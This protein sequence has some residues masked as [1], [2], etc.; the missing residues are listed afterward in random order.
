MYNGKHITIPD[1][2]VVFQPEIE[3]LQRSTPWLTEFFQRNSL[4]NFSYLDG[5]MSIRKLCSNGLADLIDKQYSSYLDPLGGVGIDAMLFQQDPTKTHINEIDPA[6]L[7]V[8]RVNFPHAHITSLDFFDR[9]SRGKLLSCSPDLVFLDYNKYTP[10]HYGKDDVYSNA[11]SDCFNSTQKFLIIND[12][13][14]HHLQYGKR[15]YANYS[16]ILGKTITNIHEYFG[17]VGE[18]YH[19]HFP[20]WYL[21]DVNHFRYTG[22][23]TGTELASFQLFRKIPTPHHLRINFFGKDE[24]RLHP[25]YPVLRLE[26]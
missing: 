22:K 2:L 1:H 19:D 11:V 12:V 26:D 21:T 15:S 17:A 14:V 23:G 8:L 10:T 6:C 4:D 20:E 9:E 16:R 13:G 25:K 3:T 18:W 5:V 24:L 7:E